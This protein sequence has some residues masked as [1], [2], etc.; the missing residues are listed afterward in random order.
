MYYHTNRVHKF[1]DTGRDAVV[2]FAPIHRRTASLERF[3]HRWDALRFFR[4]RFVSSRN[5]SRSRFV[6]QQYSQLFASITDLELTGRP[7]EHRLMSR[8]RETKKERKWKKYIICAFSR[9]TF[10]RILSVI[11]NSRF[12]I[13]RSA[14]SRRHESS[15]SQSA[16]NSTRVPRVKTVQAQVQVHKYIYEMQLRRRWTAASHGS[17]CLLRNKAAAQL[18]QSSH[19]CVTLAYVRTCRM[20]VRAHVH[21]VRSRSSRRWELTAE[22][23]WQLDCVWETIDTNR[24]PVNSSELDTR[25]CLKFFLLRVWSLI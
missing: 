12:V 21:I 8:E 20:C 10:P 14:L 16:P 6:R 15:E 22:S 19:A 18:W 17:Y 2:T 13:G 9:A 23:V 24:S 4:S 25:A 7:L 1:G 11:R 5:R 3:P